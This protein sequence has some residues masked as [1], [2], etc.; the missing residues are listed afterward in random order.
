M[1]NISTRDKMVKKL[2]HQWHHDGR[3]GQLV[4]NCHSSGSRGGLHI[5]WISILLLFPLVAATDFVTVIAIMTQ[6]RYDNEYG[7]NA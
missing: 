7:T 4:R 6:F 5:D 1:A 2:V 3:F